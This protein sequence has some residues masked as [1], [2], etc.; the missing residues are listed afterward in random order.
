MNDKKSSAM[1]GLWVYVAIVLGFVVI[2]YFMTGVSTTG[3]LTKA[4]LLEDIKN[5][6]VVSIQINQNREVPTGNLRISYINDGKQNL[7]VSDVNE[8]QAAFDEIGFTS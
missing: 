1:R 5:G 7:Y 3:S 6:K 4:Q 8:I 2:W